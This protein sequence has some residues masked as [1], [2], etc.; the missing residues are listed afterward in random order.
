MLKNWKK[1]L[2]KTSGNLT[3][4]EYMPSDIKKLLLE[5]NESL[6]HK[7]SFQEVKFPKLRGVLGELKGLDVLAGLQKIKKKNCLTVFR[8]VRFPTYKRLHEMV[9]EYGCVIPNYEQERILKL[10]NSKKYLAKRNKIKKDKNFWV[11]PQ[12]RV[13]PGLPMFSLANDALQI[14]HAYRGKQD[15]VAMIAIHIPFELFEKRVKLIANPAIDLD[16]DN[17]D[18]D[19][20]ITDFVKNGGGK[21]DFDYEALR[22]RGIDLHEV[23]AQNFPWSLIE[24]KELGISPEFFLLDIYEMQDKE[25]K[26]V[27]KLFADSELL[28]KNQYFLHGF[29]GDQNIFAR[30]ES[31]FLPSKCQRIKL[32]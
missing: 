20:E 14:H 32:K 13:V 1:Q 11:V 30:R 23:F 22:A 18:R 8:A 5:E 19:C 31:R 26:T 28:K 7:L 16:F 6:R 12:E 4:N 15:Q 2:E 9:S 3:T 29:F 24:M 25:K 17:C 21:V 27:K 10:Y